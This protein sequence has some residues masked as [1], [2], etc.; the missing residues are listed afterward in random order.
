VTVQLKP[1]AF[2]EF[3]VDRGKTQQLRTRARCRLQLR[4]AGGS[5]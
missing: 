1:Y 4:F 5:G 2:N 3:M